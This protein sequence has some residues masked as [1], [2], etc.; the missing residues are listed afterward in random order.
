MENEQ[1]HVDGNPGKMK[2][3]D[4]KK[5]R[6]LVSCKQKTDFTLVDGSAVTRTQDLVHAEES[7][8]Y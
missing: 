7:L 6:N 3:G 8:Y 4:V 5:I 1:A 2:Q